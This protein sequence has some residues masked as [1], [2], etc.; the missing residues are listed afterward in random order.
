[1]QTP[2][3][4]NNKNFKAIILLPLS[5]IYYFFY[6][7]RCVINFKPYQSKIP[8]IC[9]GNIV[10]G[11]AGK[12]P[13]AIEVAK[14]LQKN[15]KTFCFLSKGYKGKVDT[16]KKIDSNSE[17]EQVGDEPLLFIDYGDVFIS[18]NRVEGLK[19]INNNF[20]YDY[21]IMDDGLQNPT[22]KKNKVILVVDGNFA[23]GNGFIIPAGPLR[24]TFKS[25]SK[26][27]SVVAINNNKNIYIENCCKKYN[28]N[29][30]YSATVAV[31]GF[32]FQ[33]KE[34]V[35]F[36]GLGRPEKFKNTL[37]EN[38]IKIKKF[39]VFNDHYK[40]TINDL[41]KMLGYGCKLITT[42]KDWV[43]LDEK[44]KKIVDYIDIFLQ[45]DNNELEKIL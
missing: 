39:F 27:V 15:K 37:E 42:K 3:F 26:N 8:V 35:A 9:V 16:V 38:D 22:F 29:Y 7:I 10:A 5:F 41:N 31:N 1:M 23:I 33:D 30:F 19:Y 4:W 44:Y 45:F 18:K 11:G 43:K 28:L 36:C 21:I 32:R 17:A 2:K 6:K 24:E 14:F 34:Y 40:Y 20:S 13:M 25:V 12:T